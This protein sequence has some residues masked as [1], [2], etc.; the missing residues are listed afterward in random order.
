MHFGPDSGEGEQHDCQGAL[1]TVQKIAIRKNSKNSRP[2]DDGQGR[3]EADDEEDDDDEEGDD[4]QGRG[5]PC[6]WPGI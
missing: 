3:A 1:A 5:Y 2:L 4:E 6:L